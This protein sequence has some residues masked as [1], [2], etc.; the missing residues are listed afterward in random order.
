MA[1]RLLLIWPSEQ[2]EFETPGLRYKYYVS[3]YFVSTPRETFNKL[4]T[5]GMTVVTCASQ[6]T[7]FKHA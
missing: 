3:N 1:H 2:F 6:T 7:H 4:Y 5:R